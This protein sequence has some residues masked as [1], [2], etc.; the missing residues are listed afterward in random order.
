VRQILL[1]D[2]PDDHWPIRTGLYDPKPARTSRI[3]AALRRHASDRSRRRARL[4]RRLLLQPPVQAAHRQESVG[5]ALTAFPV[6]S[7][8]SPIILGFIQARP[9]LHRAE[10]L[11]NE[12]RAQS[13]P[14]ERD[15]RPHI[16]RIE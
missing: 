10:W 11:T 4:P 15:E 6:R 2:V 8:P 1:Q 3:L 5:I 13:F 16:R 7:R 12:Q 9:L 14:V